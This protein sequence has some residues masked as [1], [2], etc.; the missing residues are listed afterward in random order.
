MNKDFEYAVYYSINKNNSEMMEIEIIKNEQNSDKQVINIPVKVAELLLKV[1]PNCLEKAN[2]H[3]RPQFI[4]DEHLE[5]LDDLRE[6]GITNMYG[7]VPFIMRMFLVS[8]SLAKEILMYW[9]ESF[10]ERHP[11]E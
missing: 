3:K 8:R 9:M 1:I 11:R 4:T 6:S 10:E 5:Y 7:A 2:K